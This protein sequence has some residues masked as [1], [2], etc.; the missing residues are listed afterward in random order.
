M[1]T[2]LVLAFGVLASM[3]LHGRKTREYDRRFRLLFNSVFDSL[4]LLNREG[5]VIDAN[6]SACEFL[7]Y[8]RDNLLSKD[9]EALLPRREIPRF[10]TELL[11]IFKSRMG[12]LGETV[13]TTGSGK[14]AEVEAGCRL[15]HIA[16]NDF[17]LA[18]LRD[19]T[20]RKRAQNDLKEKNAALKEVMASIEEEKVRIKNEFSRSIEQVLL[21]MVRKVSNEDGTLN[22]EYLRTLEDTLRELA[23]SAGSFQQA[24]TRLTPRQ[25]EICD[26]IKGGAT[27]KEIARMLNLSQQTVNKHRE[28]IRKKLVITRKDI[29]LGSFLKKI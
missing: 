24:F 23:R 21:P 6:D 26:L 22:K 17:V 12:Y 5:R 9:L 28:R 14:K 29:K 8:S 25:I 27:T 2:L 3:A 4:I 11:R 7:Q 18:S 20:E 16:G 19:T 1:A 10:G 15:I 13:L